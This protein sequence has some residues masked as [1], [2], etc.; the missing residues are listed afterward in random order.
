MTD[1]SKIL[2]A[3]ILI[4]KSCEI[5]TS[6][7]GLKQRRKNKEAAIELLCNVL[8][9]EPDVFYAIHKNVHESADAEWRAAITE[10]V[11]RSGERL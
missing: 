1:R 9:I 3:A 8:R 10:A 11:K 7:S 5:A 4:A 6:T 2:A